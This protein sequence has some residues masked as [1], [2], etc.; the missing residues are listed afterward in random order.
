[1]TFS[2]LPVEGQIYFA[3][4]L[5]PTH[6][7]V[8]LM[9]AS[10][11][12]L[13]GMVPTIW[14]LTKEAGVVICMKLGASFTLLGCIVRY[15]PCLWSPQTRHE[16]S[17][18]AV[19]MLHVGQI[20]NAC[21][22]PLFMA[23]PSQLSATWFASG[24]RN[25][26]T[27]V[28][29]VFC[30]IGYAI[31]FFIPSFSIDLPL[32]L[33]MELLQALLAAVCTFSLV[34]MPGRP[35]RRG[36]VVG[37]KTMSPLSVLAMEIGQALSNGPFM[38][39]AICMGI[40]GGAWTG[41]CPDISAVM[42]GTFTEEQG[43]QLSLVANL[44]TIFGGIVIGPI[45]DRF[46]PHSFKWPMVIMMILCLASFSWFTLA[47]PT[48]SH[49]VNRVPHLRDVRQESFTTLNIPVV[50]TGLLQGATVP[51]AYELCSQL[52]YPLTEGTSGGL[53]QL[54]VNSGQLLFLLVPITFKKK[55]WYNFWCLIS[56]V[57][58][59]CGV[60]SVNHVKRTKFSEASKN[61]GSM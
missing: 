27:A 26:A 30:E 39:L 19:M 52:L 29:V 24:H 33:L 13:V 15:I 16:H 22:Y 6:I 46:F 32:I 54:F 37:L 45:T 10:I 57:I 56:I 50:L 38:M 4:G 31:A 11:L 2:S 28:S 55:H 17:E 60:L 36:S 58:G 49:Y 59:L 14:L 21:A 47:L 53:Y 41:W 40:S 51:L 5:T 8:L 20:L 61:Y 18:L 48:P 12:P 43:N 23:S 35:R 34:F 7:N 9:W 44:A 25:T 3:P 1:M 42:V